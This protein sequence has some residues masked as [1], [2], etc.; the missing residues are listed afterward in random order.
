M[1]RRNVNLLGAIAFWGTTTLSITT[2]FAQEVV[3]A[4]ILN[5][6]DG[7]ATELS[8]DKPMI[9]IAAV[10]QEK[11]DPFKPAPPTEEPKEAAVPTAGKEE[12][13]GESADSGASAKDA[14]V[15]KSEQKGQTAESKSDPSKTM[16]IPADSLEPEKKEA[17]PAKLEEAAAQQPAPLMQDKDARPIKDEEEAGKKK[18]EAPESI[19][20][21]EPE[22]EKPLSP[23]VRALQPRIARVLNYYYRTQL[24]DATKHDVWETMHGFL[25]WGVDALIRTPQ[26]RQPVSTIGWICWNKP[27]R[28]HRLFEINN[29]KLEAR[30]GPRVQGHHGQFLAMLAQ[31]YVP[32]SY[33]IQ[34][35]GQS[36]TVADLIEFEKE[37]CQPKSELTF[38]LI[39]LSYYLPADATWTARDGQEWNMERLLKEEITQ[40]V[41]GAA[42]GGTHRLTGIAFAVASRKKAGLPMDGAWAKAE[43][44]LSAYHQHSF[45]IQNRDGSFSTN[46]FEG[47]GMDRD[48][49]RR[50]QTSGHILEFLIFS[51]PKE[52][53]T[54]PEIVRAVNYITT[55]MEQNPKHDWSIGPKGHALHALVLYDQL[56]FG[57]KPG[58]RTEEILQTSHD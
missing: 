29:G 39:S 25:P 50:L 42:C 23:E 43:E 53:L 40:K 19:T 6:A 44:Y 1:L 27:C 32:A 21:E 20:D 35:D 45:Q 51:L 3:V 7:S 9:R 48:I 49:D 30:Q 22:I 54:S 46:W 24:S 34:V 2:T 52:E 8:I 4:P 18:T 15:A 28:G 37:T 47:R 56:V 41:V 36:F 58:S 55:I 38:K 26:Y 17:E 12:K 14:P 13:T 10:P 5:H 31:S 33:E 11:N 57:T 16:D